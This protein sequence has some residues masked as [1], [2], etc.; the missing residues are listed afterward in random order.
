MPSFVCINFSIII[1]CVFSWHPVEML[2]L[3]IVKALEQKSYLGAQISWLKSLFL[4]QP[5][6]VI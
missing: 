1:L 2:H 4:R 5:I 6:V 3:P